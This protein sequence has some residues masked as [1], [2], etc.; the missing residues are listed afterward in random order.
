MNQQLNFILKTTKIRHWKKHKFTSVGKLKTVKEW[1]QL[2]YT[3]LVDNQK[4]LHRINGMQC[5]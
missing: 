2:P 1:K 4:L 3:A 5:H